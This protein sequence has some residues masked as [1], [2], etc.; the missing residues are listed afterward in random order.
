MASRGIPLNPPFSWVSRPLTSLGYQ[1][2][3]AHRLARTFRQ[4]NQMVIEELFQHHGE[5]EKKYLSETKKHA[6]ELEE[7]FSAE[8]EDTSHHA[9]HSWDVD[10]TP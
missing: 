7:L 8:M 6:S 9:D 1:N 4:H 3:Q 5:D 2:Y 10:I